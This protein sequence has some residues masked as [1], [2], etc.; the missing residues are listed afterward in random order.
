[1]CVCVVCV[2]TRFKGCRIYSESTR[3]LEW[4]IYVLCNRNQNEI[5]ERT[6]SYFDKLSGNKIFPSLK[7][8]FFDRHFSYYL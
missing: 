4:R 7:K 5:L 8:F 6:A 3:Y 2:C 1:M